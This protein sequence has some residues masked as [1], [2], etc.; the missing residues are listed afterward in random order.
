MKT[1]EFIKKVLEQGKLHGGCLSND[2]IIT[3]EHKNGLRN[4]WSI[5]SRWN[6]RKVYV[7]YNKTI[8]VEGYGYR[9]VF[10]VMKYG[11]KEC[12]LDLMFQSYDMF[13]DIEATANAID[14]YFLH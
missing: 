5:Q 14:R 12:N 2:P 7:R 10:D 11:E 3:H 4:T 13:T 6:G 9:S 8:H 1:K